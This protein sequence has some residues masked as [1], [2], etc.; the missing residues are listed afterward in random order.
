MD[1]PDTGNHV[2][3][4][5]NISDTPG[6]NCPAGSTDPRCGT[7]I[8]VLIPALTITNTPSTT[9]T[10]PR[11]GGRLH[12]GDHRHRPD[13]LYRDQPSPRTS[14]GMLDDAAYDDDA[15]ATTGAAVLRQPRC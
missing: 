12:A 9:T 7:T 14:A 2:L 8:P 11:V 15:A 6:S 5:I 4:E 1:D 13:R 10:G 3:T